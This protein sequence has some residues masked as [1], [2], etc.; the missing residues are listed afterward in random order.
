MTTDHGIGIDLRNGRWEDWRTHDK[1]EKPD[2]ALLVLR[3]ELRLMALQDKC[4]WGGQREWD[5][6]QLAVDALAS[7]RKGR[8]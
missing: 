3:A 7:T 8:K 4:G 6:L 5:E 1:I 2:P